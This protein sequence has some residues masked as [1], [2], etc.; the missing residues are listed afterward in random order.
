[1]NQ[2]T[3]FFLQYEHCK[4]W[5]DCWTWP[6]N[7]FYRKSGQQRKTWKVKTVLLGEYANLIVLLPNNDKMTNPKMC[8]IENTTIWRTYSGTRNLRINFSLVNK[9]FKFRR[10]HQLRS[11]FPSYLKN[12][13]AS[14]IMGRRCTFQKENWC[15]SKWK[16]NKDFYQYYVV[17]AK[18]IVKIS[19][20]HVKKKLY[21]LRHNLL[22]GNVGDKLVQILDVKWKSLWILIILF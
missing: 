8:D 18:L 11:S 3:L 5:S 21:E 17:I 10:F 15:Q 20:V 19:A 14:E 12:L 2:I 22:C 6:E 7:L 1:M 13:P 4:R 16:T 9:W